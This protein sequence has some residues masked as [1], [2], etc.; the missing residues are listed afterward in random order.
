MKK[1][2]HNK[3]FMLDPKVKN[4]HLMSSFI[5]HKQSKG[6]KKNDKKNLVSH[7]VKMSSS[8]APLV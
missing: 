3:K 6:Y 4:L 2:A 5:C 1:K 7:F 8:F